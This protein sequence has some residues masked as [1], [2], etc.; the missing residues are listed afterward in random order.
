METVA[1]GCAGLVDGERTSGAPPA[2][3]GGA[4][5]TRPICAAAIHARTDVLPR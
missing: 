5:T 4:E 2:Y 1:S 3:T